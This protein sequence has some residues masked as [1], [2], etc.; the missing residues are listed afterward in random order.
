METFIVSITAQAGHEDQV[1]Q[2][3]QDIEPLLKEAKGFRGRKIYRARVGAM[4][5][6]VKEIYSPEELARHPEGP[7]ADAGT[8]FL[9]V[10]QWDSVMDRMLFAKNVAGGRQKDLI[11]HL[12]PDHSHEFYDEV[13]AG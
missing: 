6:A 11:P 1:A 3:Y 10:E 9:I 2:H 5:D 13:P 12:L 4:A 8:N 7:H